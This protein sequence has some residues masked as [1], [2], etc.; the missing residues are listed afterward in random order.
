MENK[1]QAAMGLLILSKMIEDAT[2]DTN[3][4]VEEMERVGRINAACEFIENYYTFMIGVL[5]SAIHWKTILGESVEIETNLLQ[6]MQSHLKQYKDG[7]SDLVGVYTFEE[8]LK[9]TGVKT[10]GA[11]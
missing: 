3:D 2:K 1:E 9:R 5:P 7:M 4:A 6:E 10:D 11:Q 8:I